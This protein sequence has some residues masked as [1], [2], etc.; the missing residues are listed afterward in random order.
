MLLGGISIFYSQANQ[1][2]WVCDFLNNKRNGYFIDVGAYDGI[3]MSNTFFLEKELGWNGICIEAESSLFDRLVQ[4][5]S[6]INIKIAVS[7][8]DGFCAWGGDRVLALGEPIIECKTL[9]SILVS[10]KANKK[11][12]YLSLDIEGGEFDALASLNFSYWDIGMMTVE[13]NLFCSDSVSKDR[14]YEL[15]SKNN[16]TRVVEDAVC[17]DS[18]PAFYNKPFEDWYVNNNLL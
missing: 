3:L 11:I 6:S 1:D 9:E 2:K 16:F 10:A 7:N 13:H 5:R 15:L 12:D 8:F 4:N 18:N 14:V 17:L